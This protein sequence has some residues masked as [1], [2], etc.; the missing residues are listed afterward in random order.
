MLCVTEPRGRNT[1]HV[2]PK[3]CAKRN[4]EDVIRSEAINMFGLEYLLCA[5]LVSKVG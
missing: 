5:H 1:Q 3:M 2:S 4:F